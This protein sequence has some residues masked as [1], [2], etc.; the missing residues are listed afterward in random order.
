[1]VTPPDDE[2]IVVPA[3]V[4]AVNGSTV[5]LFGITSEAIRIWA[6]AKINI[7]FY[8]SSFH[9]TGWP[10]LGQP[11]RDNL[12]TG[13]LG[14]RAFERFLIEG[15]VGY[16]KGEPNGVSQ[17]NLSTTSVFLV[18]DHPE[19]NS[20]PLGRVIAHEIGHLLGSTALQR[21]N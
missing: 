11:F 20:P 16:W 18:R 8:E 9:E 12:L 17:K 7:T 4:Y 5:D 2:T 1:M 3:I 13:R 19:G 15:H 10:L 6:T 21:T 14:Q